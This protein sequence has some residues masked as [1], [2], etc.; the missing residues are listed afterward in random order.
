MARSSTLFAPGTIAD[1]TIYGGSTGIG[2]DG[3]RQIRSA[4][5]MQLR[6]HETHQKHEIKRR[7]QSPGPPIWDHLTVAAEKG[8]AGSQLIPFVSFVC[9][10]VEFF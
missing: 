5:T 8:I 1:R 9:F 10:V 3:R 7:E 2:W 6:N 4:G